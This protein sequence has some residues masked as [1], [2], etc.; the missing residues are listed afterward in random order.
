MITTYLKT[1]KLVSKLEDSVPIAEGIFPIYF[2]YP[3]SIIIGENGVGKSTLMEAIAIKLG[4]SPEGGSK[5]FN[6]KTEDTHSS[7]F[8]HIV[9]SKAPERYSDTFFY[10]AETFYNFL[11]EM[12]KLDSFSS[13][14]PEI[15]TYYGG[16]TLHNLSHGEAMEC[17]FMKRFRK[18]GLYIL[19]EPEASLSAIRQLQFISRIVELS[20][21]GSQ[22]I[23][24]THSPLIMAMPGAA[25]LELTEESLTKTNFQETEAFAIFQA[26]MSTRGK[27]ILD[28]VNEV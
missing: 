15:K 10:R 27:Y 13:F 26:T 19:D 1:V 3:V 28:L 16:K 8:K 23:I 20:K 25:L 12:R 7:L 18:N 17:L 6:F 21:K 14:D 11:S 9:L 5:N 2:D 24:A 4:C 22:F